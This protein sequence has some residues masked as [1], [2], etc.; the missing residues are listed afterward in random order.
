MQIVDCKYN[1]GILICFTK[2]AL[3]REIGQK[4]WTRTI[5]PLIWQANFKISCNTT[6]KIAY[7]VT[8]HKH[9]RNYQQKVE[10]F[11]SF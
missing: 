1:L 9:L 4:P 3:Y 5:I 2:W 10:H 11:L 7:T 6:V 8:N